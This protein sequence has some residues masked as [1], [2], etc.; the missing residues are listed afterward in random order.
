MPSLSSRVKMLE[1]KAAK[2]N[3]KINMYMFHPEKELVYRTVGKYGESKKVYMDWDEVMSQ[4]FTTFKTLLFLAD[5]FNDNN[6]PVGDAG[7]YNVCVGG[8]EVINESN[9]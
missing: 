5:A 2:G 1:E 9:K 7:W 4:S 8:T 6:E 3:I